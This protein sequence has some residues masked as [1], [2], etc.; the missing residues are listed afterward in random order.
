MMDS[1]GRYVDRQELTRLLSSLLV[2]LAALAVFGLFAFIVVPGLRSANRPAAPSLSSPLAGEMGWLDPVEFTKQKAYD[3]P[4]VDPKDVMT[5][6]PKLLEQG[7]VLYLKNCAQCHGETG[8]GNGPAALSSNPPPRNFAKADGWKNGPLLPAVY[9]TLGEGIKGSSMAAFDRL[10]VQD[11]MALAHTV[12]AFGKFPRS[13]DAQGLEALAKTLA[14]APLKH[15]NRIPVSLAMARLE[16][17]APRIGPIPLPQAGDGS[18]GG[19]IL[20]MALADPARAARVLEAAPAWKGRPE[21]LAR[22]AVGGAPGNGFSAAVAT[23]GPQEWK[24][25]HGE[26]LKKV[27]P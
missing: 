6:T 8:E 18:P 4:P 13:E 21:D 5:V 15:P 27:G 7:R 14:A 19:A 25:L 10:A 17:E 12:Q 2:F 9:K 11:R 20:R 22:I 1:I 3:D 23:F 24:A 16:K 26:L